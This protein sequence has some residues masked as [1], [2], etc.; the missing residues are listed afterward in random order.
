MFPRPTDTNDQLLNEVIEK[1]LNELKGEE[2]ET[3]KFASMNAQLTELY[4]IKN[5]NRSRRVSPDT[6]ATVIANLCGIGIIV[7][8]EQKHIITSK[9]VG[10]VRKIF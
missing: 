1:V 7:G 6:W 5:E 9:A 3:E 2:P 8:Y 4:K 10:F